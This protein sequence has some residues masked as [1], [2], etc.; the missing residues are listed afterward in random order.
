VSSD[1][2]RLIVG[3]IALLFTLDYW[4]GWREAAGTEPGRWSGRFWGAVAGFTSFVCHAGGPPL[5]MY[6]L[7]QRLDPKLFAG[8]S[9]VFFAAVNWIKVVPYAALGQ[10]DATNLMTSLVLAPLAPISI[11]AGVKLVEIVRADTFYRLAYL[12]VFVVSLKLIWDGV[13]AIAGL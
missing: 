4:F 13:R 2:V 5:Q 8:T 10:F 7:P 11:F 6:L 3:T 9:A 1:H 12:F